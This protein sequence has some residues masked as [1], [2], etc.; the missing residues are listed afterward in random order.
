MLASSEAFDLQLLRSRAHLNDLLEA[1]SI[2]RLDNVVSLES[3][4]SQEEKLSRF[5][6]SV[7]RHGNPSIRAG[8]I[9]ICLM[10]I[11]HSDEE[12]SSSF[13]SKRGWADPMLTILS[14]RV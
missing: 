12:F 10:L 6:Q 4:L 5:M 14:D 9:A 1:C 2:M 13:L 8:P 3:Y 7:S 11:Y